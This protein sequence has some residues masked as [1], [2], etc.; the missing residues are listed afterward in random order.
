MSPLLTDAVLAYAHFISIF[1]TF[2]LLTAELVLCR[3]ALTHAQVKRLGGI[4][5]AYFIGAI[6]ILATG[7]ARLFAGAKGS[8]FYI[9]NPVF[10]T[11]MALFV[12][13]GLLSIPPTRRFIRWRRRLQDAGGEI[14]ADEVKG[15]ARFIHIE[16]PLMCAI[17]LMAVLMARGIGQ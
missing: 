11:K 3:G 9:H 13:V 12:L 10:H 7:L 6:A 15:A 5:V 14:A 8:A 16:L 1:A 2:G 4:D 17:P